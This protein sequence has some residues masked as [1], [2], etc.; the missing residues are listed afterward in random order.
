[1]PIRPKIPTRGVLCKSIVGVMDLM[2][3]TLRGENA[4][5]I[6]VEWGQRR[7]KEAEMEESLENIDTSEGIE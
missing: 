3:G 4:N 5:V 7:M 6:K 2:D 1:M